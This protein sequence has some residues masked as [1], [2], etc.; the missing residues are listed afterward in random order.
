MILPPKTTYFDTQTLDGIYGILP[1]CNNVHLLTIPKDGF[2]RIN[3]VNAQPNNEDFSMRGWFSETIMGQMLFSDID[4]RLIPFSIPKSYSFDNINIPTMGL[5]VLLYDI[6]NNEYKNELHKL[7]SNTNYYICIQNKQ[8]KQNAYRLV[9]TDNDNPIIN[10]DDQ[11]SNGSGF[12][13]NSEGC[14]N[15][16]GNFRYLDNTTCTCECHQKRKGRKSKH[17]C[18]KC[19]CLPSIFVR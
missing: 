4:A 17:R 5:E 15:N 8:N 16:D 13:C 3:I 18:T 6:G 2:V 19:G 14:N 10:Y 12:S 11:T 7:S 1:T 9:I